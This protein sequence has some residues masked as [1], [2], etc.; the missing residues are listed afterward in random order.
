MTQKL[1][2]NVGCG[3]RTYDFY[4][5]NECKCINFD[6]RSDLKEV[7]EVGDVRDLSRFK[8]ETFQYMLASD[9]LEH[10]PIAETANILTEWRRVLE[11]GGI[12]EVRVPDLETICNEYLRHRDAKLTSWLIMGGQDYPGNDHF[13]IFD[14]VWLK[15]IMV[16]AGFKEISCNSEGNNFV[17]KVQKV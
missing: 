9:I 2:L 7:D 16:N 12:L 17:M 14:R 5:T 13:V 4:P 1:C 3:C 8:D 15:S 10:M 6:V 11:I